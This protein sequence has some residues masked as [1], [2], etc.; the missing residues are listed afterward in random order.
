MTHDDKAYWGKFEYAAFVTSCR[1]RRM[2][3]ELVGAFIMFLGLQFEKHGTVANDPVA[4]AGF[5]GWDVRKCRRLLDELQVARGDQPPVVMMGDDGRLYN[6]RMMREIELYV[7]R[8]RAARD[9]D[10]TKRRRKEASE[11]ALIEVVQPE[12]RADFAETSGQLRAEVGAKSQR[13]FDD[14]SENVNVFNGHHEKEATEKNKRREEKKDSPLPPKGAAAPRRGLTAGQWADAQGLLASY[15]R[16]AE[17]EG[18]VV[19]GTLT[20]QRGRRLLRR[21]AD[22]GGPDAWER[23]LSV[24][25]RDDF[26]AGRVPGRDGQA[27][28]KLDVDR[29]LQT[30]GRLGDV[31]ARLIDRANQPEDIAPAPNGKAWGWWRGASG[32]LKALPVADWERGLAKTPPNGTWPWWLFGPPPGDPECLVPE[33]IVERHGWRDV[34]RGQIQHD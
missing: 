21:V 17:A 23:A 13:S 24:V 18:W 16:H 2:S 20:E 15:N 12:V 22:I 19:T 1:L 27:P 11:T 30:E 7:A 34:Y 28:F 14:L 8:A 9:R 5:T 29:L 4:F 10:E 33:E 31:L 26:L 3:P 25:K 6:P 32:K